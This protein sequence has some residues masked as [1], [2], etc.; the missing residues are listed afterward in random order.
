VVGLATCELAT[1]IR[2]GE[3]GFL[4]TSLARVL[5]AA[6]ALLDDPAEARRL[7]EG[8]RRVARARYNIDRFT[9]DWDTL[10]REVAA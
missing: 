10:L 7:G 8:A 6:R 5:E 3:S 2:N 1:V 4:D 9:R